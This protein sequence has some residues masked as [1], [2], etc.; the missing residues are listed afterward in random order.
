MINNEAIS[1]LMMSC[2]QYSR[3]FS[4][5][6]C[7][8]VFLLAILL[9]TIY[10]KFGVQSKKQQNGRQIADVCTESEVRRFT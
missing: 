1:V 6:R 4:S 5:R 8:S 3:I 10:F 2:G 9:T 7:D